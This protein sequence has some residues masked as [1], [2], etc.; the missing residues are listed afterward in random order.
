VFKKQKRLLE[1]IDRAARWG[2]LSMYN[3]EVDR[4]I[5]HTDE[6][7]AKMHRKQKAYNAWQ[8]ELAHEQDLIHIHTNEDMPGWEHEKLADDD[9]GPIGV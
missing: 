3:A 9:P 1:A 7:K 4:G 5:V 8:H 2:D 6:Y